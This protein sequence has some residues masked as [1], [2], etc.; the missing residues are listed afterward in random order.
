MENTFYL[1]VHRHHFLPQDD[2]A[3]SDVF[4]DGEPL[5]WDDS[6]EDFKVLGLYSSTERAERR[7][8]QARTLPGFRRSPDGF[9]IHEY[10]IGQVHWPDGFR[11][12]QGGTT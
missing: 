4:E 8:E 3:S 6:E 5:C 10:K 7:I 2:Q 1:L 11:I 9:L 12:K